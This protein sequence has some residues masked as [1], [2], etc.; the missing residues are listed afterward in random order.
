MPIWDGTCDECGKSA[1]HFYSGCCLCEQCENEL[2]DYQVD[3][4]EYLEDQENEK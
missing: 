1:T 3:Y 4:D 2:N